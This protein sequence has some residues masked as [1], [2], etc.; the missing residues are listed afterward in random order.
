MEAEALA[1]VDGD[2]AYDKDADGDGVALSCA[3]TLQR[4]AGMEERE[5]SHG[6]WTR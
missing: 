3:T 6:W 1:E 4:C 2:A 5:D